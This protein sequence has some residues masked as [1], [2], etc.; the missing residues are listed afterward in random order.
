MVLIGYRMVGEGHYPYLLQN[1]WKDKPYIE[2]DGGY[3]HS[4]KAAVHFMTK[5]LLDMGEYPKRY[6]ALVEFNIWFDSS[7]SV[8][9]FPI[10][11]LN[12]I[13][14]FMYFLKDRSYKHI[15]CPFSFV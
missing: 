5:P 13:Y 2:V 9:S 15:V 7:E 11:I 12:S 6:A 10:K 8:F 3:L 1:W 4:A 14:I